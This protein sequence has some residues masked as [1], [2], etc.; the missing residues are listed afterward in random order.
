MAPANLGEFNFKKG[1]KK[2]HSLLS[3]NAIS[4]RKNRFEFKSQFLANM[5]PSPFILVLAKGSY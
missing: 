3:Q 1:R 5:K 2:T 4:E